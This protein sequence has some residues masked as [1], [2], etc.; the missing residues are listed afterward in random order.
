MIEIDDI[1]IAKPEKTED[2]HVVYTD[3]NEYTITF[4]PRIQIKSANGYFY[5]IYGLRA[6]G[7]K[8]EVP[9]TFSDEW[10]LERFD[11]E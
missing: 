11:F 6:D 3:E 7:T 2:G 10:L 4:P 8:Y 5:R 1:L 9:V